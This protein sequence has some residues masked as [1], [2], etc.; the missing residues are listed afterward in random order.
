MKNIFTGLFLFSV[1]GV[2]AQNLRV[3][4]NSGAHV[5]DVLN[6]DTMVVTGSSG[7]FELIAE[8]LDVINDNATSSN[9][10]C[11]REEIYVAAG[12][13][14]ALCWVVCSA[15]YLPGEYPTLQ[16]PGGAQPM[17]SSSTPMDNTD[18]VDIFKLH[19]RPNTNPGN[20]LYK[21]TLYD[22]ADAADTAVFWV[23]F[24]VATGVNDISKT[25][26]L[27]AY[28]NPANNYVNID[29]DA[30]DNNT[31]LKIT[32]LLGA[33]VKTLQVNSNHM[34]LSTT[35]F[36]EGIYF[37]SLVNN[38]KAIVTRRLVVTR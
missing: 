21:I 35:E 22:A 4:Y 18:T 34:K 5:G 38:N 8:H 10:R 27:S 11:S 23:L 14:A 15:Y 2:S 28:P 36:K 3:V 9:I 37:Y 29:V 33:T 30:F 26:V 13:T 19:Y 6:N 7:D 12:S 31:Y 32:D 25:P 20:S 16:A 24:N 17:A 1:I